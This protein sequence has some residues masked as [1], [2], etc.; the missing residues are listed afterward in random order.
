[1]KSLIE[2]VRLS[3]E[4]KAEILLIDKKVRKA[5]EERLAAGEL[6]TVI[7]GFTSYF[8]DDVVGKC[9]VCGADVSLRSWLKELIDTHHLEVL[10]LNCA[11]SI[12]YKIAEAVGDSIS[13]LFRSRT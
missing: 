7:A 1:M 2:R 4:A 12:G 9:S 10:C 3:E 8:D 5:V 6:N 11:N 13:D